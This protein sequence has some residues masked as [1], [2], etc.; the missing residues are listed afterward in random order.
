MDNF[1]SFEVIEPLTRRVAGIL[2][3]YPDGTQIAREL[4]QNSED[5]CSTVQWFL[6]DHRQHSIAAPERLFNPDMKQYQGPALLAGND[7]LFEQGDFKSLR[8]LAASGKKDD[9]RKIGQMG[10]GFNSVYHMTDTP[11][12]ISGDKMVILEPH[13][14]IFNGLPFRGGVQGSFTE[15]GLEKFPGQL[16]LFA[17]KDDIDFSRPYNGTIFRFPLRTEEQATISELSTAPYP[18]EK[19]REMLE[20]LQH[21]A[22]KCLLFLK[23]IERLVIYERQD[24]DVAARKLF[25]VEIV[26]AS[27]VRA[28]RQAFMARLKDHVYA[29]DDSDRSATLEYSTRPVFKVTNEDG[30]TSQEKWAVVSFIDNVPEARRIMKDEFKVDISNQRLIP[31]VGLAAPVDDPNVTLGTSNLFCFLPL[32]I[33]TPHPVHINGHFAVKQS[34]RE[35]WTNYTDDISTQSAAGIKSCWNEFL[36]QRILPKAYARLL[37]SVGVEHGAN[38]DLWPRS[39]EVSYGMVSLCKELLTNCVKEIVTCETCD[40]FFSEDDDEIVAVSYADSVFADAALAKYPLLLSIL[41]KMVNLVCDLPENILEVL[42]QVVKSTPEVQDNILT[43]EA[44][45]D[46]LWENRDQWSNDATDEAKIQALNYCIEDGNIEDL[47]GLPLLPMADGSWVEFDSELKT[48][49][50]LVRP[51][52]TYDVLRFAN[53]NIVNIKHNGLPSTNGLFS[54]FEDF[55]SPMSGAVLVQKIRESFDT[56]FYTSGR[57]SSHTVLDQPSGSAFPSTDWLIQLWTVLHKTKLPRK[58]LRTLI[59]YHLVPVN[60]N[61]LAPLDF[62]YKVIHGHCILPNN[63]DGAAI[64][65]LLSNDLGC[66]V[67]RTDMQDLYSWWSD[68]FAR[69]NDAYAILTLLAERSSTNYGNLTSTARQLLCEYISSVLPLKTSVDNAQKLCLEDLPIYQGYTSSILM[70]IQS[71]GGRDTVRV[72]RGIS[73]AS[74]PWMLR[75]YTLFKED[76]LMTPHLVETLRFPTIQEAEYWYWLLRQLGTSDQNQET[77]WN[78]IMAAF[79]PSFRQYCGIYDFKPL[80]KDIAFVDVCTN[81]AKEVIVRKLSPSLLASGDLGHFFFDDEAVFPAGMYTQPY[82][83]AVLTELGMAVHFDAQFVANRCKKFSSLN[84]G[85]LNDSQTRYR[86]VFRDFVARLDI[87]MEVAFLNHSAF[88]DIIVNSTWVPARAHDSEPFSLYTPGQCRPLSDALIVGSQ[89]PV[90]PFGCTNTH[91]KRLMGWE[92]PPPL[93]AV[94][95]NLLDLSAKSLNVSIPNFEQAIHAVYRDLIGRTQDPEAVSTMKETLGSNRCILVNRS[96]HAI[97]RVA[98]NIRSEC[99]LEPHFIQVPNSDFTELFRV[100]GVREEVTP[101]DLQD[102]LATIKSGYP[103]GS[104][105]NTDDSGLV[106]RL[107]QTIAFIGQTDDTSVLYILTEDNQLCERSEVVY[108]NMAGTDSV[109]E[110]AE[111]CSFAHPSISKDVATKLQILMLSEKIWNGCQDDFFQNWEQEISVKDKI[112][113]ILNDYSSE[114]VFH[115]FLQNAADAG[116]TQFAIKLDHQHYDKTGILNDKMRVGQGPALLIWNDAEMTQKDFDGLRKLAMGSKQND[117]QKIGRH[118]LGFNTVYHLTDLPSVVSGRHMVIFDPRLAYL[119]KRQTMNGMVA[120]GAVRIDFLS[121][122]L[123]QKFPGQVAPYENQFDCDMTS[124]YK[125]T[126]FRLPLRRHLFEARSFGS[127]WEL[128]KVQEMIEKWV[129]GA[130]ISMLFLKEIQ[131][132]RFID[133]DRVWSVQKKAEPLEQPSE[134]AASS[135]FYKLCITSSGPDTPSKHAAEWLVGIAEAFGK[136]TPVI[137]EIASVNRWIPH[138]GIA[139]PLDSSKEESKTKFKGQVFSYLPTPIS[140]E[141]PFHL[142]GVFALTSD[143]RNLITSPTY[144]TQGASWNEYVLSTLLPPLLIRAMRQLFRLQLEKLDKKTV[145]NSNAFLAILSK[146]FRLWPQNYKSTDFE[147]FIQQFWELAH[148]IPVFPVRYLDKETTTMKVKIVAGQEACFPSRES[149]PSNEVLQKLETL[150]RD[151]GVP[152]CEC[153]LG[154]SFTAEKFWSKNS[155][156]T[157]RADSKMIRSSLRGNKNF[158]KSI[159]DSAGRTWLLEWLLSVVLDESQEAEDHLKGL[160]LLPLENG[161]WVPLFPS[162]VYYTADQKARALFKS[163][164]ILVNESMFETPVLRKVLMRLEK[165]PRYGVLPLPHSKLSELIH[166]ENKSSMDSSRRVSI[167]QYLRDI[168]D[169]GSFVDLPILSTIWGT[170]LPLRS[171]FGALRLSANEVRHDA[172]EQ[173]LSSVLQKAGVAVFRLDM[174]ENHKYLEANSRACSRRDVLMS[175]VATTC[176][177][178]DLNFQGDQAKVMRQAIREEQSHLENEHL[179]ALGRLKIWHSFGTSHGLI[180]AQGHLMIEGAYSIA[181]LGNNN[182]FL[183]ET[184]SML[185]QRMGVRMMSFIEFIR[186]KVIPGLAS[187]VI[188]PIGNENQMK[189]YLRVLSTLVQIAQSNSGLRNA[190]IHQL[191][192]EDILLAR[193]GEPHQSSHFNDPSDNLLSLVYSGSPEKFLHSEVWNILGPIRSHMTSIRTSNND[194]VLIECASAVLQEIEKRPHAQKT[195]DMAKL[196]VTRIYQKPTAT[197]WMHTKWTVVPVSNALPD[198]YSS[199]AR[200]LPRFISFAQAVCMENRDICWTQCGFFPAELEPPTGVEHAMP[201]VGKPSIQQ[202]AAHLDV[203][204]K[205]L[206]PTWLSSRE[207]LLLQLALLNTYKALDI[208]AVEHATTINKVLNATMTTPYILN[209]FERE[210]CD[211]EAWT[212]PAQLLLDVDYSTTQHQLVHSKMAQFRKFLTAAGVSEFHKVEG[213]VTV[214]SGPKPGSFEKL[215][216]NL[217]ETQDRQSGFM[218]VCFRFTE[219]ASEQDCIWAHKVVL[220]HKNEY[221]KARFMGAWANQVHN[222]DPKQPG[223]QVIDMHNIAKEDYNFLAAFW[224]MLYYL[225]SDNLTLM[226]GPPTVAIVNQAGTTSTDGIDAIGERVGY[227]LSL[228]ALAN[229][230]QIP[231]LKALI[232]QELIV[233]QQITQGN[234]FEVYTQAEL[235]SSEPIMTHCETYVKKNKESLRS[236]VKGEIDVLKKELHKCKGETTLNVVSC[237]EDLRHW[238]RHLVAIDEIARKAK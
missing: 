37:D 201:G 129:D 66:L 72:C 15:N 92:T 200:N 164:S 167:W 189:A 59:G 99:K 4:L 228:L 76:Q 205:K 122:Q 144:G 108:N 54:G 81:T 160:Y 219:D 120:D 227:L 212:W 155:H 115:E 5:A 13:M 89:M 112:R 95:G 154:I 121:T 166:S 133:N 18:A 82:H 64:L 118:G 47:D 46:L 14:R 38:Y 45:R 211:P 224:G 230:Y 16:E 97:D 114:S 220:A 150:M 186:R 75:D 44:V 30:S 50:Y 26:N 138:R 190:A 93:R 21:E 210:L 125:G 233:G 60:A 100:L 85:V 139:L 143:R 192:H 171:C 145:N 80:L 17:A 123:A 41:K 231:R 156:S 207:Q 128:D 182:N 180:A 74:H 177:L 132:I 159:L 52:I 213:S 161:S 94:L 10:I 203:M 188:R 27:E 23:Y 174:H 7:S 218:D 226:N 162:P 119:P 172:I 140:T 181:G 2:Q 3:D 198:P 61:R 223:V 91:L 130:K 142:H 184:H 33:Q 51:E 191:R 77:A 42:V 29:T 6:L 55:M 202:I 43:P 216:R 175:I 195:L 106:V 163:H 169:L 22:I 48:T 147:S 134:D 151:T 157:N 103:D 40:V 12:F 1:D 146:Y 102:I 215:I 209:S 153:S 39:S 196:L 217:F 111:T 31:W 136:T 98:L 234:V 104:K 206:A 35:I 57:P 199:S 197:N 107:L 69:V 87:E 83:Q 148:H 84:A 141:Q 208:L 236:V 232:A 237:K 149:I 25:E 63:I 79:L 124:H 19:V 127:A 110:L 179:S 86:E 117:S 70:S 88:L 34:R 173:T 65:E 131:T 71:H 62:T 183:N 73:P 194:A 24:S 11:S 90:A 170:V 67:L 135:E 235:T 178:S 113:Q 126:L 8:N 225:Y 68:C 28:E 116:A 187:G 165:D 158:M 53:K 193:N 176:P 168:P 229:E 56:Q 20:G 238:E 152:V 101:K 36:F 222:E 96:L 9:E 58:T 105:L 49:R 185:F 32:G 109:L 78:E 204:A 221:F 214:E 137:R